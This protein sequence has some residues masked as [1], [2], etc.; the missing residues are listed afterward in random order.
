MRIAAEPIQDIIIDSGQID[1]IEIERTGVKP[2]KI[3]RN[4]N[5]RE[6]SWPSKKC[7]FLAIFLCAAGVFSIYQVRRKVMIHNNCTFL[8]F[9]FYRWLNH[10]RV[11]SRGAH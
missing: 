10:Y 2:L 6:L 3:S 4:E 5:L 1:S 8:T 11:M 7:I 9:A